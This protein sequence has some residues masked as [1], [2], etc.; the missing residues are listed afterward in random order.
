MGP[1]ERSWAALVML[2]V[3]L[4]AP[5]AALGTPSWPKL[6]S[7]MPSEAVLFQ[8]RELGKSNGKPKQNQHFWAQDASQN[9]PSKTPLDSL[10]EPLDSLLI[11]LEPFLAALELLSTPLSSLLLVLGRLWPRSRPA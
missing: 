11:R 6:S 8:K 9:A 2:V 5:L 10:L 3:A 1:L 4:G 7:K